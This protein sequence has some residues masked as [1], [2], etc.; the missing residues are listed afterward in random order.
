MTFHETRTMFDWITW[1]VNSLRNLAGLCYI[2]KG[3]TLSKRSI[4]YER[5]KLNKDLFV[6]M[7]NYT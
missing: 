1:E 2:T 3:K 5:L 7:E 6:F 4:K